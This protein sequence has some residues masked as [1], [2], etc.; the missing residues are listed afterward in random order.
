M[1][2]ET[3]GEPVAARIRAFGEADA[4]AAAEILR[5]SPEA[6]QWTELGFRELLRWSGVVALISE[7]NGK[8]IGFVIGRQTEEEAEILNLAIHLLKRRKGEGRELLKAVL[9]EFRARHV[10]RVF[11]EVRE[12][13]ESAILFYAK[14]GFSK[15]GS[16][17]SYYR[18]PEEA[19][20][21]MSIRLG[22]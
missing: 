10:T 2:A 15:R 4:A 5:G 21:V 19:A 22:D 1:V 14:H 6:A 16:R 13:N 18:N 3:K 7:D 9:D 12:S 8:V 11:L 17:A 20:I